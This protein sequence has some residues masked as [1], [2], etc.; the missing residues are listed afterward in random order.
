MSDRGADVD[1]DQVAEGLGQSI[2]GQQDGAGSRQDPSVGQLTD[3]H[4]A[5]TDHSSA[6]S[7]AV[8]RPASSN[9][10]RPTLSETRGSRGAV[11][12][13][14]LLLNVKRDDPGVSMFDMLRVRGTL[15]IHG[16]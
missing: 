5:G 14:M 15:P 16:T 10:R 12:V 4:H 3:A 6:N 7:S 2:D 9:T 1:D 8:L 11:A 13:M